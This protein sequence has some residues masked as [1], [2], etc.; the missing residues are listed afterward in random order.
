MIFLNLILNKLWE[1]NINYLFYVY[2]VLI[3]KTWFLSSALSRVY[4]FGPVFRAEN[5]QTRQ[6]ASEFQMI[7]AEIA[8]LDNI[9]DLI[10][11]SSF[12]CSYYYYYKDN[13]VSDSWE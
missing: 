11:V 9:E 6:H 13:F 5:S 1:V 12:C 3:L 8:F 2:V 7:E 4:N 10:N